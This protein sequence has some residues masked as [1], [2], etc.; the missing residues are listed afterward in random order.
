M[1]KLS[2]EQLKLE[3]NNVIPHEQLN[4]IC[5]GNTEPSTGRIDIFRQPLP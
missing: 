1:K 2:L 3:D 4:R 5:G